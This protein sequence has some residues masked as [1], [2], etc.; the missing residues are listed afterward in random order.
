MPL[1]RVSWPYGCQHLA[2][3]AGS[4]AQWRPQVLLPV[5]LSKTDETVSNGRQENFEIWSTQ[6]NL[7]DNVDAMYRY[8]FIVDGDWQYDSKIDHIGNEH[9]SF[10]NYIVVSTYA[11]SWGKKDSTNAL[12][13]IKTTPIAS[14]VHAVWKWIHFFL[15]SVLF[16][17]VLQW[18]NRIAQK[19]TKIAPL[20]GLK[21]TGQFL[22]YAIFPKYF[23]E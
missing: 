22:G 19:F 20:K 10:D 2:M 14:I 15:K 18:E 4:W 6:I 7:P 21:S 13:W 23:L 17:K 5:Q 8:K 16:K 1:V 12:L 3:V 9:G 11:Y